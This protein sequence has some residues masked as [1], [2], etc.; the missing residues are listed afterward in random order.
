MS[1]RFANHQPQRTP[2]FTVRNVGEVTVLKFGMDLPERMT[3]LR[4]TARLWE[5]LAG[6]GG[7]PE[8]VLLVTGA[9]GSLSPASIDKF[10]DH[11]DY[12]QTKRGL[13][14]VDSLANIE[15]AREENAVK[16]FVEL[17]RKTDSFV[18][19]A[20]EGECDFSFL[21]ALL[22]CDYR[23]ADEDTLFVNRLLR[24][25]STPGVL[26]WFLARFLSHAEAAD[27]L[28][29]GR[30]LTASEAYE[31]KLVNKLAFAGGLEQMSL[32]TAQRFANIPA[33]TLRVLK[34]SLVA[35]H[36]GLDTYLDQIGA[37]FQRVKGPPST[38][39]W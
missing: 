6:R 13:S 18:I 30:S 24:S 20:V 35:S 29:E 36:E 2:L 12:A 15:V 3:E 23:I 33:P 34:R 16:H 10:W 19:S 26:P 9:P 1:E 5:F 4:K 8:K 22:A 25:E 39:S 28:L 7:G 21:G 38:D 32:D 14:P 31:L 37:G 17:I 11:V 27:I